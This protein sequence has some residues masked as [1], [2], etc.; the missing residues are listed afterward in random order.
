MNWVTT[1]WKS[2]T[3]LPRDPPLAVYGENQAKELASYFASLPE[4]QRPTAIFSSPYYRCLQTSQP[5]SEALGVPIYVEHGISEWYSPV[6]AGTG[7]HPRPGSAQELRA[8]VPHIDPTWSSVW[9][10]SRKGESVEEAHERIAGLLGTLIPTIERTFPGKHRRILLVSHAATVIALTR[11]LMGERS[12]PLRVGCCSL[13]VVTRDTNRSEVLG[14]WN[15]VSLASGEHL[16]EGAT[17]DW[18]FEDILI[19]D[20]KVVED[21]GIPGTEHEED[22]PVGSQVATDSTQSARM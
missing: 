13:T 3:E 18:G 16:A 2:P 1:N 8:Y 15:P 6:K 22:F 10:A 14:A 7:L 20:G 17:R 21:D 5:T 9:Y 19:K 4:D 11:E 12:L